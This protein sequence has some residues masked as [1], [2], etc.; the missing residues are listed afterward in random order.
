MGLLIDDEIRKGLEQRISNAETALQS[1]NFDDAQQ[2]VSELINFYE[3][4]SSRIKSNKYT[5]MKQIKFIS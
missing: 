4:N 2:T 3:M 5:N 1:G